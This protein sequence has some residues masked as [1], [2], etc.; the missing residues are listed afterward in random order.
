M[1]TAYASM[2]DFL[3]VWNNSDRKHVIFEELAAKGVFLDELAGEVGRDFDAFD[4]ICHIAFDQPPLTRRE[5]ADKV[6]KKNVFG[7]YGEKAREVLEA[8][9]Q[10]YAD[11]GIRSVESLEILKVDP[12]SQFGTAIEILNLFGGKPGYLA[13]LKDLETA[14]YQEAA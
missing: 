3:N 12:L 13:A 2:A 11:T 7:K 10:K 1:R 6:K 14:L 4:L 9:L 8:L 5:R